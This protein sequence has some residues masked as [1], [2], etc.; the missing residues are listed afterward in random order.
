MRSAVVILAMAVAMLARGGE[1]RGACCI[2]GCGGL[3]TVWTSCTATSQCTGGVCDSPLGSAIAFDPNAIC[4]E[5]TPF[6][7]CP[8]NERGECHDGVNNDAWTG[9]VLTDCEDPDCA[10]DPGCPQ[11]APVASGA[12]LAIVAGALLAL[13]TAALRSR[14]A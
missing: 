3:T 8:P 13:G 10:D 6:S 14:R 7:S 12:A 1:A 2:E 4:G 11:R 5:G 9:D